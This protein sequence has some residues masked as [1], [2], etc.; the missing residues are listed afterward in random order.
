MTEQRL[1]ARLN[2]LTVYRKTVHDQDIY[3]HAMRIH[4]AYLDENDDL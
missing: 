4:E 2:K 1:N 3:F